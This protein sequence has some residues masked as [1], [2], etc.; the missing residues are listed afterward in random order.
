MRSPEGDPQQTQVRNATSWM[1]CNQSNLQVDLVRH[2]LPFRIL[3]R[4]VGGPSVSSVT[5]IS[6]DA[7]WQLEQHEFCYNDNFAVMLKLP[8]IVLLYDHD[9]EGGFFNSSVSY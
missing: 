8:G 4:V 3:L 6:S 9:H 5:I 2:Q 1:W 7:P